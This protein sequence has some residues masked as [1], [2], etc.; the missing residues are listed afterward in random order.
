MR[1]HLKSSVFKRYIYSYLVVFLVPFFIFFILLNIVFTR[2]LLEETVNSYENHIRQVSVQIDEDVREMDFVSRQIN[3][4]NLFSSVMLN[5]T[6]QPNTQ[7]QNLKRYELSSS[8]IDEIYVLLNNQNT[9]YSS[10]GTIPLY[11]ILNNTRDFD[12][13]E[14]EQE[15]LLDLLTTTDS[16]IE[17]FTLDSLASSNRQDQKLVYHVSPL[18]IGNRNIGRI[19]IVAS[20]GNIDY[21]F[22]LTGESQDISFILDDKNEMI[23]SQGL[24]QETS[25]DF[26]QLNLDGFN[27][28]D[29]NLYTTVLEENLSTGWTIVHLVP[30][31]RIYQPV[32]FSLLMF[33]ILLVIVFI[34]GLFLS[35]YFAK[36]N[37]RPVRDMVQNLGDSSEMDFET[38]DEWTYIE[39]NVQLV[40]EE[41]TRLENQVKKQQD[42]FRTT[43]FNHLLEGNYPDE[44]TA[45]ERLEEVGIELPFNYF[46]VSIVKFGKESLE[47]ESLNKIE[48]FVDYLN[49]SDL[50][51]YEIEL[52]A[53]VSFM[54]NN[55]IVVLINTNN[56]NI[57]GLHESLE[58]EITYTTITDQPIVAASSNM[59]AD[60][61]EIN[62]AFIEASAT[63]EDLMQTETE[64]SYRVGYFSDMKPDEKRID[65][66]SVT[67]FYR[68]DSLLLTQSIKQAN[69]QV[70]FSIVDRLFDSMDTK[71]QGEFTNQL[72]YTTLV[73]T[74]VKAADEMNIDIDYLVDETREDF[75]DTDSMREII[76]RMIRAVS[77]QIKNRQEQDSTELESKVVAYVYEHFASSTISLE[78]IASEYNISTSY[79]S[80][81]I[82]EE[83]GQTF[84]QILQQLRMDY[85]KELLIKTNRPIKD[86]VKEI[87]YYDVSNFTRKFREENNMTPSQ[88]RKANK[89]K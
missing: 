1:E 71:F 38:D 35:N 37:Y 46:A 2:S 40:Q 4:S 73:G 53:M 39:R 33:S 72:L 8:S 13:I 31:S 67:K 62:E 63:L 61:N 9:V 20:T 6:V 24:S 59:H 76:K 78:E 23:Y 22:N 51:A 60:I 34:I 18:N 27:R 10:K 19:I 81:L 50:S 89:E 86:L 49:A 30:L 48:E 70:A 55:H 7:L 41:R 52:Q 74:V 87:G 80:K 77:E 56:E 54:Q 26:T 58:T 28:I 32:L 75:T 82:S 12:V 29:G 5:S 88:Y 15:E 85:F 25:F 64:E 16:S 43:T 79:V 57:E 17:T 47:E 69:N 66:S 11:G 68:D 84:T 44:T 65:F 3:Q 14:E 36:R 45:R 21:R 83:T 42:V